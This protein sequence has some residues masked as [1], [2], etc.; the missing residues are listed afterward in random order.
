MTRRTKINKLKIETQHA[1][2][3]KANNET[4]SLALETTN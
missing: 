2:A 4:K 3:N 1:Q